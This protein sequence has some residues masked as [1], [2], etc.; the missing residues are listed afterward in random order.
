M[1]SPM[2]EALKLL[3]IQAFCNI[4]AILHGYGYAE[5]SILPDFDEA[6]RKLLVQWMVLITALSFSVGTPLLIV[7]VHP[8]AKA[9]R[10]VR[11]A[12]SLT[13]ADVDAGRRRALNLPI[14]MTRVSSW[15]WMLAAASLPLYLHW[16]E[17]AFDWFLALH[18]A[19]VT[20]LIGALASTSLF[21]FV[22]WYLRAKVSPLL[23]SGGQA[24]QIPGVSVTPVWFKIL[25]L[26]VQVCVLPVIALT[27]AAW[28]GTAKPGAVLYLGVSFIAFGVIQGWLIATSVARPVRELA[29]KMARV[30][31]NDLD[32]SAAVVSTDE[33]G[34]LADGFNQMV[35]GLRQAEFVKDTF[36]R[37]VTSQVRDEILGGKVQLGGERRTV[38]VLFSDIR[39]YTAMS[40]NQQPEEVVAFLNA[41]L[42]V[43]VNIIVEEGGTVDK[44]IGDAIMA[45]FGVPLAK[46]DDAT[47]AVRAAV[48]MLRTLEQLNADRA[49]GGLAPLKIGIGL[50]TGPVVAGNIGSSK[51]MEY[52]IIGDAV[53]TA[54]RIEQLTKTLGE[55]L[56]ISAETHLAAGNVS[57]RQ[58]NPVMVKGKSE[59]L[60]LFAVD[61]EPVPLAKL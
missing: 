46:D 37:Y 57:A 22:E 53:N 12:C 9:L 24:F 17:P 15:T 54:S 5:L 31:Q 29:M 35:A 28:S 18:G 8:V 33:V 36:G 47:R 32:A 58:L 4:A 11:G 39:D 21:Y 26:L 25:M 42:D 60:H 20:L 59:P 34:Q 6:G 51:K 43:M 16:I 10:A 45:V 7:I 55:P 56:L 14:I 48:R 38:T 3:L 2:R 27:F 61:W 40:E 52:T 49:A 50:H 23:L 1:L 30:K 13:P 19:V 41:Y 44:F